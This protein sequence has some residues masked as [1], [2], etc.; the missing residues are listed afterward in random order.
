[1]AHTSHPAYG[2]RIEAGGPVVVWAP[3]FWE[4]PAWAAGADLMF[5]ERPPGAGRS[6]S[7]V[8]PAGV[9]RLVYA[10]IG[11]PGI[12]AVDAGRRPPVGE[13]GVEGRT[14]SVRFGGEWS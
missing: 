9:R 7:A 8:A 13:W 11:R 12:R 5:A 10:H 6:G 2:Y 14:Y 3:E 4:F 1:M